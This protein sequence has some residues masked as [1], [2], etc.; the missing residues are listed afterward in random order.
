MAEKHIHDL[1]GPTGICP[2]GFELKIPRFNVSFDVS[3]GRKVLL[4]DGF[5]SDSLDTIADALRAAADDLDE[6]DIQ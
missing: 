1:T 3:D 6:M 4:Q 5:N 2:C